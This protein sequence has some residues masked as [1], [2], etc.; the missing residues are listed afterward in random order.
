[1]P[2]DLEIY[3]AQWGDAYDEV[4]QLHTLRYVWKNLLAMLQARGP[5]LDHSS[6][7]NNWLVTCYTRTLAVGI[8][9]QTESKESRATIGSLLRRIQDHATLFTRESCGFGPVKPHTADRDSWLR[10]A[11]SAA[12]P[13]RA[14][15]LAKVQAELQTDKE[16]AIR[17]VN[18]RVAHLDPSHRDLQLIFED[19]ERALTGLR[20]AMMFL[21]PLFNEGAI[22][23][24]ATPEYGLQWMEMFAKPWYVPGTMQPVDAI[25]LG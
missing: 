11:D 22:S 6:L 18:K 2:T 23:A 9:R 10:Y 12:S 25:S 4:L 5:E 19:L 1:M 8:R 13:L 14:D 17:W 24:Y 20:N 7:V 16:A 15:R 3:Q 21:F